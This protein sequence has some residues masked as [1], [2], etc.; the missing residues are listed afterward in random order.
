MGCLRKHCRNQCL[1]WTYRC[2]LISLIFL[3]HQFIHFL[4]LVYQFHHKQTRFLLNSSTTHQS[5]SQ[6]KEGLMKTG[7][8]SHMLS[9]TNVLEN[10]EA[11]QLRLFSCKQM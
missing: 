5:S 9:K 3:H 10:S 6:M 1:V 7:H 2:K 8:R 11:Q 4:M